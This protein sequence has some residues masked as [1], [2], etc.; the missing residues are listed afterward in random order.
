MSIDPDV[1]VLLDAQQAEID[2]LNA[3]V[4]SSAYDPEAMAA[5]SEVT[6][7]V[8]SRTGDARANFI[9]GLRGWLEAYTDA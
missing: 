6:Q 2:A 9:A 1:Q 5:I 7:E 3:Q 4:A 8:A